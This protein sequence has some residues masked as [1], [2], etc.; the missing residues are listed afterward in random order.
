M[1]LTA[2]DTSGGGSN[3]GDVPEPA[4]VALVGLGLVGLGF[5]AR[6]KAA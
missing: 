5:G 1:H 2:A 3:A 6:K 4:S